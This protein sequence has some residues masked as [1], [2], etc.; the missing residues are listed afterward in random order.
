MLLNSK[1]WHGVTKSQVNQLE[2]I[3]KILL[4][5]IFDAHPKTGI[6]WLYSDA[7]K[8]NMGSLLQIRRLMYLWHILSRD[9]NELIRRVYTTQKL[10]SNNG[11][12]IG[13]VTQDKQQLGID[14]S[15]E[16]IQG[17]SKDV[18]KRYVTTKVKNNFL[19]YLKDMKSK[20]SKSINLK[21]NELKLLNIFLVQ[22]SVLKKKSYF[23]S[24]EA[25][26]RNFK[27]ENRDPWYIL[28]VI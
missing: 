20:H 2:I 22:N 28:W 1:V 16:E 3:D 9:E 10:S 4:R 26:A 24:L 7:G 14:M 17:V 19:Q 6:E 8:L 15:D 5:Y 13:L 27:K 11:D 18:F 21:C 25:G 23:S 12:W